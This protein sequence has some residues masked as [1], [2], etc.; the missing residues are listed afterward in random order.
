MYSSPFL[1]ATQYPEPTFLD[2]L[3][4]QHKLSQNV[5]GIRLASETSPSSSLTLGGVDSTK[6]TGELIELPVITKTYWDLRLRGYSVDGKA[7]CRW[8]LVA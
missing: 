8:S 1:R 4:A 6:F 5:F 2:N 7:S 3:V